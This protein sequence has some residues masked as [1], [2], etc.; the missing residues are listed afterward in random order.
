VRVLNEAHTTQ[1]HMLL[2]GIIAPMRHD[3][4]GGRTE[5]RCSRLSSMPDEQP[6]EDAGVVTDT[7]LVLLESDIAGVV[8]GVLDVPMASDCDCG[9]AC[10]NGGI[11][12]IV[13]D[14]GGAVPEAG[15]GI[16][17]QDIA[18]DA[19]DDLD[20]WFPLG[21]SNRGGGAEYL[22]G[23]GFMSAASGGDLGVAAGGIA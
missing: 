1:R 3:G 20:Q 18:G 16:T 13:G 10:G 12:H 14:L 6:G 11:G 22:G 5:K 9:M 23:P 15:L 21:S 2:R 8:Q 19:C 7:G 17:M 4:C